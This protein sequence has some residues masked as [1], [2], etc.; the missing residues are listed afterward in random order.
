MN[1]RGNPK[2]RR[3]LILRSSDELENFKKLIQHETLPKLLNMI[4]SVNPKVEAVMR[5]KGEEVLEM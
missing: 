4:N 3:G 2:K 1:E 5:R